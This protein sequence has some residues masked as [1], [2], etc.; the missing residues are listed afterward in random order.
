MHDSNGEDIF[1][2]PV[3]A[4]GFTSKVTQ[5][6]V[7]PRCN[8]ARFSYKVFHDHVDQGVDFIRNSSSYALVKDGRFFPHLLT[9]NVYVLF[10]FRLP[11]LRGTRRVLEQELIVVNKAT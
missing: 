7:N 4:K 9:S 11:T 8:V 2:P 5:L 10:T 6:I 1:I 3:V